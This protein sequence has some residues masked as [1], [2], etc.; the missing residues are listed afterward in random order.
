MLIGCRLLNTPRPAVV[1]I[2]WVVECVEQKC[3]VEVEK[4]MI[5]LEGVN[6]AGNNKVRSF[7][8]AWTCF[9]GADGFW[10]CSVGDRCCRNRL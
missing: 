8:G 10:C 3:I 9:D 7:G 6:V 4:F 2:A 1:G 5:D